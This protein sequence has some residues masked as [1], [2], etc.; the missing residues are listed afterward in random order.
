M[1]EGGSRN[2]SRPHGCQRRTSRGR[3]NNEETWTSREDAEWQQQDKGVWVVYA[4]IV[5]QSF[6]WSRW[7]SAELWWRRSWREEVDRSTK[8]ASGH[9]GQKGRNNNRRT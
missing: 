1:K 2:R 7:V 9:G 3:D 4:E 6:T 5:G 8:E